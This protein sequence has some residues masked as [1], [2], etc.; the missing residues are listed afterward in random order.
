M[1]QGF[2]SKSQN[3]NWVQIRVQIRSNCDQTL[4]RCIPKKD[5]FLSA[6]YNVEKKELKEFQQIFFQK[7]LCS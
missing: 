7:R 6:Y 3:H 4:I 5:S 1:N 2:K